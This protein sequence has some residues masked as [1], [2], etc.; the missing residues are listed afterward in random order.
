M[1]YAL[2][3]TSSKGIFEYCGFEVIDHVFFEAVMRSTEEIRRD[4]LARVADIASNA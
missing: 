2:R 1:E 3:T 4:W